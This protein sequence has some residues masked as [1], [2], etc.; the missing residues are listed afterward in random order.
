M[1]M[2]SGVC[3][4]GKTGW[5]RM[6]WSDF[7]WSDGGLSPSSCSSTGVISSFLLFLP[8]SS[9]HTVAMRA[10]FSLALTL[11]HALAPLVPLR[12]SCCFLLLIFFPWWFKLTRVSFHASHFSAFL[13]FRKPPNWLLRDYEKWAVIS[14]GSFSTTAIRACYFV[15]HILKKRA[16]CTWLGAMGWKRPGHLRLTAAF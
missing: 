12:S 1:E 7:R 16:G 2:Y 14:N 3:C 9:F 6:S 10:T 13:S 15:F 5:R 4:D 8:V 11:L